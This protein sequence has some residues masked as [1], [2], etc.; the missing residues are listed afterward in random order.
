MEI[1]E[2]KAKAEKQSDE[3]GNFVV[4]LDA[5]P[6]AEKTKQLAIEVAAKDVDAEAD[7][8]SHDPD[9]GIVNSKTAEGSS[10]RAVPRV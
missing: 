2:A 4:I 3:Q 5:E 8:A 1:A 9:Q 7:N 6:D 10:H